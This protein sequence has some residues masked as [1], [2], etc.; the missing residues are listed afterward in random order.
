MDSFVVDLCLGIALVYVTIVNVAAI[1]D[2]RPRT[3]KIATALGPQRYRNVMLSLPLV[4]VA[5]PVILHVD[6][7]WRAAAIVMLIIELD[8]FFNGDEPPKRRRR[9]WVKNKFAKLAPSRT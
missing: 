5:D 9:A 8:N 7:V 4:M 6:Y 3:G 1:I 2:G